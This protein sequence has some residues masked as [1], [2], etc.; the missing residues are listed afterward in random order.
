[1][2]TTIA[3]ATVIAALV[4]V[5]QTLATEC[6]YDG[7]TVADVRE[8]GEK[9]GILTGRETGRQLSFLGNVMKRAKLKPT[10]NFRRSPIAKSHGNLHRV[11]QA[12]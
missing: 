7:I 12:A 9:L 1:M 4:P 2:R 3:A 5:A 11:W 10:Q 8:A 6:P